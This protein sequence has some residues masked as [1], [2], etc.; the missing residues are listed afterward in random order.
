MTVAGLGCRGPGV[1]GRG[2]EFS[3]GHS[4]EMLPELWLL[5][6]TKLYFRERY[7]YQFSVFKVVLH[8]VRHV[9]YRSE[10]FVHVVQT[11]TDRVL[12]SDA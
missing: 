9:L 8:V 12:G 3:R 10:L 4:I 5:R 6:L 2:G 11:L 1:R 7:L